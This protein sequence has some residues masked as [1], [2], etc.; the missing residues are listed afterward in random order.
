MEVIIRRDTDYPVN[1]KNQ[2]MYVLEYKKDRTYCISC[3]MN[4]LFDIMY[5]LIKFF[6]YYMESKKEQNHVSQNSN[7]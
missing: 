7:S 2:E 6:K 4:E 1:L 5:A 3:S